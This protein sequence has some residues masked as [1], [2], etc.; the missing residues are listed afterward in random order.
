MIG[1]ITVNTL[2]ITA[3]Q[4]VSDKKPVQINPF[5]WFSPI[6]AFFIYWSLQAR[7]FQLYSRG[8]LVGVL[9]NVQQTHT[10][11]AFQTWLLF[12]FGSIPIT[13]G[14]LYFFMSL[15]TAEHAREHSRQRD[16][17]N[18]RSTMNA[19]STVTPAMRLSEKFSAFL[20]SWIRV[21][22][23]KRIPI[24]AT[25]YERFPVPSGSQ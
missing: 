1:D 23:L 13:C 17:I 9:W 16:E 14:S 12:G 8:P 3:K 2:V 11:W 21:H 15:A 24:N 4:P 22:K 20:F 18:A 19:K 25:E 10:E 6:L 5:K 7:H